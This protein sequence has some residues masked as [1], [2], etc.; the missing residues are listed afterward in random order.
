MTY[1]PWAIREG[2]NV[3]DGGRDPDEGKPHIINQAF[4]SAKVDGYDL[5]HYDDNDLKQAVIDVAKDEY[6][7]WI[8]SP[9]GGW[10]HPNAPSRGRFLKFDFDEVLTVSRCSYHPSI[11]KFACWT[12]HGPIVCE[13]ADV[14]MKWYRTGCK[15]NDLTLFDRRL[16]AA[17]FFEHEKRQRCLYGRSEA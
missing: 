1:I 6:N 16:R 8:R 12:N 17:Q 15:A 4:W 7:L 10:S 9:D 3:F 2:Y 5:D 13:Y 11:N 14:R